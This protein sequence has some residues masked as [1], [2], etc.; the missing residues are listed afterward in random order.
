MGLTSLQ[1]MFTMQAKLDCKIMESHNLGETD[2]IIRAKV[3][4]LYVELG[5]LANETR[6]FKYWSLKPPSSKA[7]MLEEICRCLTFCPVSRFIP[8]LSGQTST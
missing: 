2:E 5:E 3:L 8:R 1:S 7:A 6:C 4:A